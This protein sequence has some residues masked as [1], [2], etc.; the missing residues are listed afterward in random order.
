M[1]SIQGTEPV[2]LTQRQLDALL[3]GRGALEADVDADGLG[4][5]DV[6]HDPLDELRP[7]DLERLDAEDL[8][9][10][11]QIC[12]AVLA[13]AHTRAGGATQISGYLGT[14]DASSDGVALGGV[15]A[16]AWV[17]GRGRGCGTQAYPGSGPGRRAK[18]VRS[19]PC[20]PRTSHAAAKPVPASST[21]PTWPHQ[22][23]RPQATPASRPG[24][25]GVDRQLADRKEPAQ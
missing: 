7:G 23:G 16:D 14:T 22:N 20:P 8:S 25:D 4:Q 11:G 1:R 19:S 24:R 18:S 2:D 10:Y 12:G 17:G 21:P 9:V 6:A 15:D 5:R 13:R 3:D